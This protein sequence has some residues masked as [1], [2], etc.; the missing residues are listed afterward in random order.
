MIYLNRDSSD[1]D[2]DIE[3]VKVIKTEA[4]Q[5]IIDEKCVQALRNFAASRA[6]QKPK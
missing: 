1:D 4:M 2:P 5:R 6:N 3:E